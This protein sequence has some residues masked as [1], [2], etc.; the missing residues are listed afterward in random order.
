MIITTYISQI[1]TFLEPNV[2]NVSLQNF[3]IYF[4]FIVTELLQ[5]L[6]NTVRPQLSD[7][8]ALTHSTHVV[9]KLIRP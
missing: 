3:L 9:S 8:R 4:F 2:T 7:L 1:V 6:L 5:S